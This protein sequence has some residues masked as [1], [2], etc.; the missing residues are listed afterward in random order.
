MSCL[1]YVLNSDMGL[2][3]ND[4]EEYQERHMLSNR[5]TRWGMLQIHFR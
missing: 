2:G 4:A 3:Q 1:L 5:V